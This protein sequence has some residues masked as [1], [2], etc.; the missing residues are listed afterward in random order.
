M[1][2]DDADE[3]FGVPWGAANIIYGWVPDPFNMKKTGRN[4]RNQA[5][6]SRFHNLEKTQPASFS[7]FWK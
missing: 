3:M 7:A 6:K 2:L 5:R 4:A 1:N